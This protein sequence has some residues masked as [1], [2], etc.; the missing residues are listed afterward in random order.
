MILATGPYPPAVFRA[1]NGKLMVA[2]GGQPAEVPEGTTL[3]EVQWEKPRR[4][5]RPS[6]TGPVVHLV[7]GSSNGLYTVMLYHDGNASCSCW[8]FR[9][10]RT[11]CKHIKTV[12]SA[13]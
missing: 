8:G 6:N 12:K 9:R 13:S 1:A 4:A 3:E 11:P 10:W 2:A 5:E 7:P